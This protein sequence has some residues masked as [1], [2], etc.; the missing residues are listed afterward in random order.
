[1]FQVASEAHSTVCA[2]RYSSTGGPG[3]SA[4]DQM[5]ETGIGSRIRGSGDTVTSHAARGSVRS[6]EGAE[7][8]PSRIVG[9]ATALVWL[10]T[11]RV[12]GDGR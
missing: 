8:R 5:R 4:N 3:L 9:G 2:C 12:I 1:V 10:G 6:D 7:R 11:D